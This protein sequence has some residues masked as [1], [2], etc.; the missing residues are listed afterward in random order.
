MIICNLWPVVQNMYKPCRSKKF[1]PGPHCNF[2]MHFSLHA[3][4]RPFFTFRTPNKSQKIEQLFYYP[5]VQAPIAQRHHELRGE[6]FCPAYLKAL[7]K[8][9]AKV[10]HFGSPG[11]IPMI[12]TPFCSSCVALQN[13]TGTK[14]FFPLSSFRVTYC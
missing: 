14:F 9:H 7:K 12:E 11:Q 13:E 6:L 10:V 3:V 2:L 4:S 1:H 5:V 8:S